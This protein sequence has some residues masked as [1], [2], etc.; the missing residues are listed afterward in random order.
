MADET[1]NP[2]PRLIDFA[3]KLR[4][5][6]LPANVVHETVRR[7]VDSLA[8][9]LGGL[10]DPRLVERWRYM[11]KR[12][13]AYEAG[14]WAY[15]VPHKLSLCD[16]AFLNSTMTRWLDYNDT[17]LA[18]EPAHPSDNLGFLFA[19]SGMKPISGRDFITAAVIAYDVQ[20]RLTE[21][22]SLRAHGWDHVNYILLSASLAG[23][24]LLGFDAEQMYNAVAFALSSNG[25]M[26]QAREGSYLSEQKNMAAA[27]AVRGAAWALEKVLSGSDGPAEIIEGK[28]GLVNQMSGPLD[29][30]AFDD[31]GSHFLLADTYI[32]PFPVEY[33][34]Q[35]VAEHAL[36]IRDKLGAPKLADVAEVM[37]TGYEAQ[38]T[39]IGDEP[40]RRPQ[41]KETADHS[42]YYAFAATLLEGT[43]SL[44]QY[45]DELLF[46][47]EILGLIERT[48][49]VELPEYTQ[50]YYAPQA[51]R[52]FPSSAR[53]TLKDGRSAEDM[54]HVPL[55]H[56]KNPMSDAQM[57]AKFRQFEGALAGDS[58]PLLDAL[59]HLDTLDDVSSVMPLTK[60][61]IGMGG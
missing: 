56:P 11:S 12:P 14:G 6:D 22:A 16:A 40:K 8:T 36:A 51:Q 44:R 19:M 28:H 24:R 27:D 54:R 4:F 18:K 57:E 5:E 50:A 46:D 33:H 39:I 41:T 34:G 20:C 49:F 1:Y 7:A 29:A 10:S 55:G 31:L 9:A 23:A 43:L 53:V 48:Q 58:R 2:L 15:G 38:R 32:K 60:L 25:A 3:A 61:K 30:A 17:Y 13:I 47:P 59:W 42:L 26:R 45:R 21:A 35:T 37:I 52:E